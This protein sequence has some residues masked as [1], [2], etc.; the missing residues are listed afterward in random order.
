MLHSDVYVLSA[1]RTPIGRFG[2][3]LSGFRA[4]E[5]GAFAATAALERARTSPEEVDEVIFG[6]AR[7]AGNGPNTARQ[8]GARA[9]VPERVPAFTVNQAC[10]SGLTALLLG[11]DAIQLG[12]ACRVLVGGHEAM[13][14][15][16]YLLDR[17]RWGYRMGHAEVLDGMTQDGFL[18]PLSG[19]LMGETAE[20]LANEYR[21]TREEQDAFAVESQG[22]TARAASEGRFDAEIVPLEIETRKGKEPFTRDEHPRPDT[23][24]ASLSRLP[25]VFG[26]TVTAGN[27]SGI[28]DGGAALVLGNR[29]GARES[30]ARGVKPLARLVASKVVGVDP[31]RMGIG[32]VPAVRA[33]LVETGLDLNDIELVELNE[34]FAVQALVC[35]RE[36][37][38]SH[39]RV[40]ANGGAIALGHPI[41]ATGARIV[42]TLL[43]ELKRRSGRYGLATL[44]VSGGLGVAALFERFPA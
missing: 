39:E 28:T 19:R 27:A 22:R 8:V 12:R 4:A 1:A 44:C 3:A 6:H 37:G 18:C 23:T 21:V 38:L 16:P 5:L 20:T 14:R 11:A 7:Q 13:S 2:G 36:L 43:H 15:T 34:A 17:A 30:E 10:A 32:P 29:G 40:N 25:P 9:R 26:G 33:L 41:G 31:A 24:F 35:I 42:V